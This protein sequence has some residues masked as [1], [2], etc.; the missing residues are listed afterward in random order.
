[1]NCKLLVPSIPFQSLGW[2]QPWDITILIPSALNSL[3]WK[4]VETRFKEQRP[5]CCQCLFCLMCRIITD[6]NRRERDDYSWLV[7]SLCTLQPQ[8]MQN[9]ISLKHSGGLA[10]H[11]LPVMITPHSHSTHKH[12]SPPPSWSHPIPIPCTN[13]PHH[14]HTPFPFHAQ[15]HPIMITLHSHSTHEYPSPRHPKPVP[16]A[17]DKQQLKLL[18]HNKKMKSC[19]ELLVPRT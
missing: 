9:D 17:H 8:D 19:P 7:I 12:P 10:P 13:T 4:I 18:G 15:T 14:D 16:L 5:L 1:M 2:P 6:E 11:P 3:E